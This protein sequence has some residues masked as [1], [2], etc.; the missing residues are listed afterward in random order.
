MKNLKVVRFLRGMSQQDLA[1][2]LRCSKSKVSAL[3]Q[4]DR[5]AG[6][7]FINQ[8]AEALGVDAK[9]LT[10]DMCLLAVP[11]SWHDIHKDVRKRELIDVMNKSGT[12]VITRVFHE[13]TEKF[14]R[15]AEKTTNQMISQPN[16]T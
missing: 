2:V 12:K 4:G 13:I 10:G 15:I 16:P 9:I 1:D 7:E 11:L 14:R 8:C 5:S 6:L 3:E